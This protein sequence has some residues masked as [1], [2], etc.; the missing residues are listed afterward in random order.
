MADNRAIGIFDSGIGGLT[1]VSELKKSLPGESIVYFGD[2]ARVPYGTKSKDTVLR[3]S[4]ENVLFLLKKDVKFIVVA[5]NTASSI[6][7][8]EIKNSFRVPIIG[9]I[10][11]G[12]KEAAAVTKNKK[13]GVVGTRATIAS[14]AYDK[15]IKQFNKQIKVFGAP[16]PLFVSLVEEGWLAHPVTREIARIYLAPLAEKNIDT[17][18]LGCTHY[19]L[20]KSVIARVLNKKVNIVDSARQVAR[21]T[22]AFLSE[23]ALS[24][25]PKHS[26]REYYYVSD[27]A[28]SFKRVARMFLGYNLDTVERVNV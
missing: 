4:I 10:S 3:F 7:L 24:C 20:L 6:A 1:V 19:P 13:V 17:L 14:R 8:S 27:D 23:N 12:A 11:A 15:E 9:V 18:I 2:T 16:C 5:C 25:A 22:K 26:R 21:Q 28:A